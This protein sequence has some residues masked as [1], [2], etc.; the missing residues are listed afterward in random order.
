M[1]IKRGTKRS[2]GQTLLAL[3]LVLGTASG[4]YGQE[5]RGWLGIE[6][7]DTG[8]FEIT[9]VREGSP[10]DR[11]DLRVGDVILAVNGVELDR[12]M[13]KEALNPF[14]QLRVGVEGELSIRR[15]SRRMVV[16]V[17]PGSWVEAF[18][19]D[20]PPSEVAVGSSW[21][22]V[23][24]QLKKL[25]EHNLQL[26]VALQTAEQALVRVESQPELSREQQ[27]VAVALRTEIDSLSQALTRSQRKIR[28]HADSLAVRTLRV[29][30]IEVEDAQVQVVVPEAGEART[31]VIYRDAVAGARFKELD[32]DQA[33]Y[34]G[35]NDGLLIV[36]VAEDTPAYNAGLREFDV[37]V[38]VN[39]RPVTKIAELRRSIGS[40]PV[41]VT[42]VRRGKESTCK[43][44]SD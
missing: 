11:A 39:G 41:E 2:S 14:S 16:T 21:D 10:A 42:Y 44:G 40:G 25:K 17:V 8:S 43:I 7:A 9:S 30:P 34:F 33:D 13:G 22:S 4:L 35:V 19:Y 15:D 6:L 28:I 38:A 31:I 26:Q 12:E 5:D 37:V 18:G 32:A 20:K 1:S 29:R 24:V 27:Q 3:L 36:E 23:A